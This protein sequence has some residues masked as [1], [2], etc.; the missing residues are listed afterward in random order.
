MSAL[1]IADLICSGILLLLHL[2][3]VNAKDVIRCIRNDYDHRDTQQ[4]SVEDADTVPSSEVSPYKAYDVI[5][6]PFRR[7]LLCPVYTRGALSQLGKA[8]FR[9]TTKIVFLV[10]CILYI[11]Q[12]AVFELVLF[13][14]HGSHTPVYVNT[15]QFLSLNDTQARTA[16]QRAIM[17][18]RSKM[19][20]TLQLNTDLCGCTS[21]LVGGAYRSASI[22]LGYSFAHAQGIPAFVSSSSPEYGSVVHMINPVVVRDAMYPYYEDKSVS[23][24][25]HTPSICNDQ[26]MPVTT[27][28]R[29][30]AVVSF[31]DIHGRGWRLDLASP[32]AECAQHLVQVLDGHWPCS[33]HSIFEN[34]I[35]H[36]PRTIDTTHVT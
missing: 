16:P 20:K 23:K 2:L 19:S 25:V 31:Q 15:L 12:R 26:S 36:I 5:S 18:E 30:S 8:R 24:V 27:E 3:C 32:E 4:N 33:E 13:A 10:I 35:K 29:S 1:K 34:D 28:Y 7:G 17:D 14:P 9:R 11:V 21:V 6:T 22:R